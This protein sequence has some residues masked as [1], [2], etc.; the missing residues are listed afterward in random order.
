MTA[1]T[2][3]VAAFDLDGTLTRGG[4]LLAFLRRVRGPIHTTG[5]V[6]VHSPVMARALL[7]GRHR[8]RAKEALLVRLL[9][10]QSLVA[11]QG[12]AAAFA[13]EVVEHRLRHTVVNRVRAHRRA[14]HQLVIV[15]ASPAVYVEPIGRLLGFDAVLATGL[16]VGPDGRLTGR[17]EGKNCRGA[18]KVARLEDWTGGGPVV[19][20]AYGDS[21]GDRE[22]LAHADTAVRLPI[23]RRMWH[24]SRLYPDSS[25]VVADDPSVR[26]DR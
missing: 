16:E 20:Y 6:L 1:P 8:D 14:G 15:S 4:T 25:D 21:A 19:V 18:E 7:R 22:L 2:R 17:I 12:T 10:H 3:T 26:V 11:L 23:R 5:A 13:E 9:E 24:R